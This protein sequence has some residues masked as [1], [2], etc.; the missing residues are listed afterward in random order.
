MFR[1]T[2]PV[3]SSFQRVMR[4]PAVDAILLHIVAVAV[5]DVI[6]HLMRSIV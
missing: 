4:L 3:I 2:K 6:A 5:V 1:I